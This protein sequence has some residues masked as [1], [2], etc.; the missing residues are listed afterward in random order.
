[1]RLNNVARLVK[2]HALLIGAVTLLGLLGGLGYVLVQVPQYQATN[3]LFVSIPGWTPTQGV[4]GED[5]P[6][7]QQRLVRSS[8]ELARAPIVLNRVIRDLHL[9]LT[10]QQLN[11]K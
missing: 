11:D 1:M 3:S 8:A 6:Q 9:P 2:R 10:P 5:H 7:Q 4:S